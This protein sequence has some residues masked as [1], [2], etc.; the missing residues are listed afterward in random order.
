MKKKKLCRCRGVGY[1]KKTHSNVITIVWK[2]FWAMKIK[3]SQINSNR[4]RA[5][6]IVGNKEI[7]M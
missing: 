1:Q 3:L 4:S 5:T 7:V 2:R 6:K